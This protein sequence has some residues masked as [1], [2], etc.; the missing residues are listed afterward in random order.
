MIELGYMAKRIITSDWPGV[1][2]ARKIYAVSN[3]LS[4]DFCDNYIPFWKHNGFWFFDSPSL[5][6]EIA[7]END[8][9]LTETTLFYYR[10]YETQ[11]DADWNKW[12]PYHAEVSFPTNVSPPLSER[13]LG[14]DIVTYLTQN[15]PECSPLSCNGMAEDEDV[16]VNEYGLIDSLDYAIRSLENGDFNHS[17]PGPFRIIGVSEVEWNHDP[18]HT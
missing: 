11:F 8:L 6:R 4:K 12:T 13:F 15:A 3:C 9:D 7:T 2:H 10:G 17:E 14:Y 16:F 18:Q 5:I 1:P